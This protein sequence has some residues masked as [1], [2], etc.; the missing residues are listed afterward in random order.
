VAGAR[1]LLPR[2]LRGDGAG[3]GGE[4]TTVDARLLNSFQRLLLIISREL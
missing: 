3:G 4:V 1:G 2:G